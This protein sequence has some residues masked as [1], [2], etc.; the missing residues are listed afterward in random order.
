M[1]GSGPALFTTPTS[2]P[3]S[4]AKLKKAIS[5]FSFTFP[6]MN[7]PRTGLKGGLLVLDL[8]YTM[9]DTKRLF[10]YRV[11]ARE[12]ERPGLHE[13]SGQSLHRHFCCSSDTSLPSFSPQC[14]HT[15]ILLCGVRPAT[16][17]WKQS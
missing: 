12:A 11:S 17:G 9:A 10:N 6:V 8:D 16:G 2:F 4:L 13:V 3:Q 1:T 7:E 15:M 14:I 5:R